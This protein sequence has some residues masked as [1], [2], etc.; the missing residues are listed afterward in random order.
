MG[1]E[2]KDKT[3][4]ILGLGRIG[5]E[6]AYRMQAFGMKVYLTTFNKLQLYVY[7]NI[8]NNYFLSLT[9]QT[10]GYDPFLNKEAAAKFGVELLS[11][12]QI[13]PIVDYITVHTPLIEQTRSKYLN[14]SYFKLILKPH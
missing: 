12:E 4:G 5:R 1:T 3:I 13:W 14:M 10:V 8:I 6:V 9:H 2:I 11:L 7:N